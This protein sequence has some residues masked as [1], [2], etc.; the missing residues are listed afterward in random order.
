MRAMDE[1]PTE[2]ELMARDDEFDRE[3]AAARTVDEFR[4]IFV[5]QEAIRSLG[6]G[7][8]LVP[9]ETVL[10]E[11]RRDSERRS[12]ARRAAEGAT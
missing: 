9:F 6:D 10:A 2:A 8:E 12:A 1:P 3:L 11:L 7:D 4:E 5:R